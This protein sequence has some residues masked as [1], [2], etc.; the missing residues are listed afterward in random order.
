M[1]CASRSTGFCSMT[2]WD[3]LNCA[4]ARSLSRLAG[5]ISTSRC[6]SCS[7]ASSR[8]PASVSSRMPEAAPRPPPAPRQAWADV[9]TCCSDISF[10][11]SAAPGQASLKRFIGSPPT[12]RVDRLATVH[13]GR[14]AAQDLHICAGRAAPHSKALNLT[15]A[16]AK[17]SP[18]RAGYLG[19]DVANGRAITTAPQSAQTPRPAQTW[20]GTACCAAFRPRFRQTT[21]PRP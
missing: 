11:S 6:T 3:R 10:W 8:R 16:A 12:G 4:S 15:E 17:K 2:G 18:H 20:S 21:T 1:Y 13:A 14:L 19:T 7:S 9:M 5:L